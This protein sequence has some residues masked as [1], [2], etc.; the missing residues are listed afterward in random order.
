MSDGQFSAK[1]IRSG[2]TRE[3]FR[4]GEFAEARLPADSVQAFLQSPAV[5][6]EVNALVD[7]P[8]RLSSQIKPTPLHKRTPANALDLGPPIASA[9][10]VQEYL[11]GL[12]FLRVAGWIFMAFGGLFLVGAVVTF[13]VTI[14]GG[15]EFGEKVI[16]PVMGLV[17]FGLFIGGVGVWFGIIR[18]RVITEMC[19]FCPHGM[20]WRIENDFDWYRWE[21]VPE[22]Y[23]DLQAERPAVGISFGRNVSWI[24]FSNTEPSRHLVEH[25]ERLASAECVSNMLQS[26]AE[27]KTMRFGSWRLSRHAIYTAGETFSWRDVLSVTGDDREIWI[28]HAHGRL[29]LSLDE[30]PYPS[31]FAALALACFTYERERMK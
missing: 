21:D 8:E 28:K 5:R 14:F 12:I 15:A 7:R 4:D 17:V 13:F 3:T 22:V 27:G 6:Q 2:R 16:G 20:I 26:F 11:I 31:L 29:S 19:W 24:S 30:I 10:L 18:G 1:P 23:C 9:T 25:I